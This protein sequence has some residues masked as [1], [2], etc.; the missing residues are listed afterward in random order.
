MR[1]GA[2]PSARTPERLFEGARMLVS[3]ARANESSTANEPRG[4]SQAVCGRRRKQLRRGSLQVN[5]GA[6]QVWW[7]RAQPGGEFG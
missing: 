4:I 3:I 1:P 5:H 7:S 2:S 6:R